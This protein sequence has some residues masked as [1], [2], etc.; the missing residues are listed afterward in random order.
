MDKITFIKFGGSAITNKSGHEEVD[1]HVI[2]T[3]SEELRDVLMAHPEQHLVLGHGSGSFGHVYAAQYH[4]HEGL[5]PDD[6][7]MGFAR[8]SSAALRLNR[9]VVD[10]LIEAGIPAMSLQPSASLQSNEGAIATWHTNTIAQALRYG[11]VPVVYGDVALDA[12]QGCAI[13]STEM[14]LSY[15]ALYTELTPNRMIIVGEDAVYTGDPHM[16]PDAEPVRLISSDNIEEML[17]HTSCSHATD[18]TGGMRSKVESMWNLVQAIPNLQIF[19]IGTTPGLLSA[20][21][22]GKP[23]DEGTRIVF[24]G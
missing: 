14:L 16:E 23:I 1:M 3:L 4:I 5:Q 8:T 13:I 12:I 2:R 17:H 6:D 18:V 11:L 7:W 15:L 21:L 10:T 20:I 22:T 24:D 19:L 9:I